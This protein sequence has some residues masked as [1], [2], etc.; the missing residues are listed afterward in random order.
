M[1]KLLKCEY[2]KT[3]RRYILPVTLGI[4]AMYLALLFYGEYSD[5]ALRQGWWALLYQLPLL[6]TMFMPILC[7]V[8]ASRLCDL[9]HKGAT[10]KQLF[11]LTSKGSLFTAKLI[12][13]L[14]IITVPILIQFAAIYIAGCYLGFGGIYPLNLYLIYLLSTLLTT[15]AI[16]VF[17]HCMSMLFKN[18]AIP[19]FV[20]IGG[21]FAGLFSMFLPQMPYLRKM[22]IWGYYG[23]TQFVGNN[24]DRE[25]RINDFYLMDINYAAFFIITIAAILMYLI[26]KKLF[27][28]KEV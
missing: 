23:D 8:A 26:G 24:W 27:T 10:F 14:G 1:I 9:E 16:Y 4:T 19:F 13:G 18:Q 5:D 2:L 11:T 25:T 7:I 21:E 15:Y 3:R 6:N 28:H 22:L 20:G 17:Q 12:Y